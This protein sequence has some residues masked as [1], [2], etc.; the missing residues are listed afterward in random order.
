MRRREFIAGLAGHSGVAVCGAR[1][2]RASASHRMVAQRCRKII[3]R[4]R[5]ACKAFREGL[6]ASR[7]DGRSQRSH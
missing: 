5:P 6:A 7:L 3:P 1:T 4:G 2:G